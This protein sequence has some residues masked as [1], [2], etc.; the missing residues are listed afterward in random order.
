MAG[1]MFVSGAGEQ[2]DA[3]VGEAADDAA[4]VEDNGAGCAGDSS[5]GDV[6]WRGG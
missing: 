6:R 3:P 5:G 1:L 4:G 2:E